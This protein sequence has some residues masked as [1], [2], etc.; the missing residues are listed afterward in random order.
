V[1]PPA[2]ARLR[3]TVIVPAWN[4]SVELTRHFPEL[5][6]LKE[7]DEVIVVDASPC[8]TISEIVRVG[9]GVYLPAKAPNRGA[10]MNLGAES[11]R[12]DVFIFH[13]ADSELT[14]LHINAIRAALQNPAVIGGAFYRKF[15]QRHPYLLPLE[16]LARLFTR[17]GGSF[18]GDQ[19]IFVRR[20]IFHAL[21]GFGSLPLMED[22]EFSRRLRRAGAVAVLDPPISSSGRRH[23]EYGAWRTTAENA[24]LIVLYRCGFSPARLH[25]W[26]YR[27]A[28]K[29]PPNE[30]SLS[31]QPLEELS[32][33]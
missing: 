9:G 24:L 25:R 8:L 13:H 18:F 31:S 11:A 32:G 4:D 27:V 1:N 2:Q 20:E 15:D 14:D 22:L 6:R 30:P 28:R 12:G 3:L 29:F 10:Q 7:L 23:L 17:Y 21:G 16:R 5:V 33:G 26:Y 19:S